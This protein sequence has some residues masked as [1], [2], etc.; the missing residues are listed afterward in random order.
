MKNNKVPNQIIKSAKLKGLEPKDLI[1]FNFF[2]ATELMRRGL[3]VKKI[4]FDGY[5]GFFD[6]RSSNIKKTKALG[7]DFF[8]VEFAY[9]TVFDENFKYIDYDFDHDPLNLFR[10]E[11]MEDAFKDLSYY[12]PR[13]NPDDGGVEYSGVFRTL[14][15]G[16]LMSI[17]K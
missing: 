10:H 12:L 1:Y 3:L 7:R 16:S 17:S 9:A 13:E 6:S 15:A 2:I 14:K 11:G 5:I 8:S 4:G